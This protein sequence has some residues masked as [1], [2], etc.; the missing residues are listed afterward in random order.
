MRVRISYSVDLEDI[1]G[2]CARMLQDSLQHVGEIHR[3]IESLIDKLDDTKTVGWQIKDQIDHCRQRLTKLDTIL[4]DNDMILQGY[5][6][7]KESKEG[8]DVI[9]EG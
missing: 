3:E 7:T 4:S 8:G 5:H 2:E 9:S 6:D 1:P